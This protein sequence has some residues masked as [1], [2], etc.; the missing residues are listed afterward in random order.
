[1]QSVGGASLASRLPTQIANSK[2]KPRDGRPW[3]LLRRANSHHH[4]GAASAS[5]MLILRP[6]Q[7]FPTIRPSFHVFSCI[8]SS[9]RQTSRSAFADVRCESVFKFE[10]FLG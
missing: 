5:R 3:V 10:L 1:M 9:S 4:L 7:V 6:T 8:P 2:P